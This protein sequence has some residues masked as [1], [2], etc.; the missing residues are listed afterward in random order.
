MRKKNWMEETDAAVSEHLLAQGKI[1]R[2][3][4]F[5]DDEWEDAYVL[6]HLAES[7]CSLAYDATPTIGSL[8]LIN[9]GVQYVPGNRETTLMVASPVSCSCGEITGRTIGMED[10]YWELAVELWERW[11]RENEEG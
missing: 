6:L 4:Y 8:T 11:A 7:G 3:G 10:C 1:M 5:G 2:A 9:S